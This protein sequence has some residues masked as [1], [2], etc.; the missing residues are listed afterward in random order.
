MSTPVA[1]YKSFKRLYL[2]KINA[3]LASKGAKSSEFPLAFR[4]R[5]A[6][7]F[8]QPCVI[9]FAGVPTIAKYANYP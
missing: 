2:L 7:I 4:K 3:R 8:F 1:D 6:K 5:W 9:T